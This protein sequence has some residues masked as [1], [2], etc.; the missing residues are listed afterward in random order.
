LNNEKVEE[1]KGTPVAQIPIN[2]A[3]FQENFQSRSRGSLKT[4]RKQAGKTKTP[5]VGEGRVN[6]KKPPTIAECFGVGG[7]RW[8]DKIREQG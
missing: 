3:N 4:K 8:R 5:R 1:I 7:L 6:A 2:Y